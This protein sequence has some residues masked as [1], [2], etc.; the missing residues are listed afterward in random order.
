MILFNSNTEIEI[1]HIKKDMS[2]A[3][4]KVLIDQLETA[5]NGVLKSGD[6]EKAHKLNKLIGDCID[7]LNK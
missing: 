5:M 3:D 4:V 1:T 6:M 2:K 7:I